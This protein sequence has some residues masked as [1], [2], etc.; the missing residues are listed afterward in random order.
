MINKLSTPEKNSTT[1]VGNDLCGETG[2]EIQLKPCEDILCDTRCE[3]VSCSDSNSFCLIDKVTGEPQCVCKFPFSYDFLTKSCNCVH[4][5]LR[6][7]K[8]QCLGKLYIL[9]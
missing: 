6:P 1:V 7:F 9:I 2:E 4:T 8:W 5:E 3:Q